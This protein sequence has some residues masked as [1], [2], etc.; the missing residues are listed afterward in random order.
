MTTQWMQP[1]FN[2]LA[3]DPFAVD[4][5]GMPWFFHMYPVQ[6]KQL[7]KTPQKYKTV[8]RGRKRGNTSLSPKKSD[9]PPLTT[10]A[11]AQE[12][13]KDTEQGSK[14]DT[15]LAFASQLDEIARNAAAHSGSDALSPLRR[16]YM[17]LPPR[18]G[19]SLRNVGNGLYANFARSHF[20]HAG[21]PIEDTAPFPDPIPPSGRKEYV[22]YATERTQDGCDVTEIDRASEWVGKVCN[23]C[24]P[25]H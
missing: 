9:R 24:D 23:T 19:R 10:Q 5:Y 20:R 3:F 6:M 13:R 15:A 1:F 11:H 21:M 8:P 25:D 18:S 17:T 14:K 2:N 22:G 16:G 4:N 12:G 7:G